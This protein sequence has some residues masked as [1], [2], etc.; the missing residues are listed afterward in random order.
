MARKAIT[1]VDL[2]EAV[3]EKV[4]LS[5][6]ESVKLVEVVLKE[7]ADC[8]ERGETVKLSSFGS[9]VVRKRVSAL[10]EIPK[11][12]RKCRYRRVGSWCS[13]PLP[14]SS[15]GSIPVEVSLVAN[16]ANDG[17][18]LAGAHRQRPCPNPA[19]A[20]MAA[21]TPRMTVMTRCVQR[22]RARSRRFWARFHDASSFVALSGTR[23][24]LHPN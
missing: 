22:A 21:G 13:S 5:R 17:G 4:G 6:R 9:F 14:S 3:Y 24:A 2:C 16:E 20:D 11:P 23:S 18:L 7:I 19:V 1:R 12:A 10:G 15:S 8:L